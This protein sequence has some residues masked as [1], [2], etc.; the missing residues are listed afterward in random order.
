MHCN[1]GRE[2]EVEEPTLTLS[3]ATL[4]SS[5]VAVSD[6]SVVGGEVHVVTH[7]SSILCTVGHLIGGLLHLWERTGLRR[8]R[9]ARVRHTVA[10]G[11]LVVVL[12]A[13][14]ESESAAGNRGCSGS[15]REGSKR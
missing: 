6:W 11:H 9:L 3:K 2:R 15:E 12:V 10:V 7:G 14:M 5:A 4:T 13:V 1:E 8:G